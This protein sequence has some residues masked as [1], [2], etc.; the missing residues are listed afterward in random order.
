MDLVQ[1]KRQRE[2]ITREAADWF[3]ANREDLDAAQRKQFL[4][5]LRASPV[6]VEEY[7]QIA[8]LGDQLAVSEMDAEPSLDVLIERA[9]TADDSDV[10]QSTSWRRGQV[11]DR[12]PR[13]WQP[14]ALAAALG[15]LAL[16]VLWLN[17]RLSTSPVERVP[18][19]H[20]ATARGE[21]STQHLIDGSVLYLNTDTSVFV[22][23]TGSERQVRIERG[24]AAFQVVH[25]TSRPFRVIAGLAEVVDV[26]TKFDVYCQSAESTLV[27]VLEGRV[28]VNPTRSGSSLPIDPLRPGGKGAIALVAGQQVRLVR[29]EVA[30]G[31]SAVDARHAMAWLE[32][33]I[34]FER[35]PLAEVAEEFNRYGGKRIEIEAPELRGLA[36]SGSF[37][38]DDVESFVAFLG[39]LDGV[40]VEVEPARI[41]VT[42]QEPVRP[43]KR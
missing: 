2:W 28:I 20:F 3:V 12:H 21:Q 22:R 34:A 29:G 1:D 32:H 36:I 35:Q 16:G 27:T 38:P 9:R 14:A 40:R 42:R 11:R 41:R 7:L 18:E 4:A 33:R 19:L 5:W 6:H 30:F 8:S 31:P 24:E 15:V 37:A 26:G 23:I 43:V 39:T 10:E 17:G 25:D 13:V